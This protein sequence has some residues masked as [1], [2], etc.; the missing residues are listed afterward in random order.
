M[1]MLRY[2]YIAYLLLK[3]TL[4]NAFVYKWI[5]TPMGSGTVLRIGGLRIGDARLESDG[6][7]NIDM[8]VGTGQFSLNEN[9]E[10][11]NLR[12]LPYST[13]NKPYE[14]RAPVGTESQPYYPSLYLHNLDLMT[15]G[16]TIPPAAQPMRLRTIDENVVGVVS[17]RGSRISVHQ[18]SYRPEAPG[19]SVPLATMRQGVPTALSSYLDIP[20]GF[21]EKEIVVWRHRY[22]PFYAW[23]IEKHNSEVE[24]TFSHMEGEGG[25]YD[26]GVGKAL[27]EYHNNHQEGFRVDF[28]GK[29]P[30]GLF[31]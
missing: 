6:L 20:G 8:R 4:S 19:P 1:N 31:D 25:P 21:Q 14:L 23:D 9:E 28:E 24:R 29:G 11:E 18:S 26:F 12:G 13:L 16:W 17:R 7:I 3:A 27:L 2:S 5:L 10:E 30:V 15:C 22:S